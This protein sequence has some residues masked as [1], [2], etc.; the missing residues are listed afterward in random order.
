MRDFVGKSRVV[1]AP[2]GLGLIFVNPMLGLLTERFGCR[3]VA[4][5]GTIVAILGTLPFLYMVF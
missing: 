3:A 1:L 2:M 4:V 5:G